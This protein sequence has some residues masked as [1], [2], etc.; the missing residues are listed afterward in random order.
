M[1]KTYKKK[2]PTSHV[3]KRGQSQKRGESK[4]TRFERSGPNKRSLTLS[5]PRTAGS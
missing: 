3:L 2:L 5:E 4:R 1:R